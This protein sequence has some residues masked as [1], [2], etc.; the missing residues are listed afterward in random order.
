MNL[1][2]ESVSAA[3]LFYKVSPADLLVIVDDMA[4]PLGQLRLRPKGSAGGHNGLKDIITK[5]GHDEFG[6][7]RIG[8]GPAAADGATSHVLGEFDEEEKS[9]IDQAIG[10]AAGAV[11]CWCEKGIDEAM[12]RYNP[13]DQ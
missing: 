10:E 7:L 11:A 13:K 12:N 4:L 2:G 6:R 9:K 5:L 1:S 8:I 3:M